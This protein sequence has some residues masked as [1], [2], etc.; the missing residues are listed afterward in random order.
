MNE[1][2]FLILPEVKSFLSEFPL[3]LVRE[4]YKSSFKY[5]SRMLDDVADFIY[6]LPIVPHYDIDER[7]S[8]YFSRYGDNLQYAFFKRKSSPRTT[9]YIFFTV[10]DKTYIVKHISTN[11][12]E[13]QYIR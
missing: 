10:K 5:A 12:T 4:G 7:F 1:Y 8:Y 13:G 9:W 2:E 6:Q 3:L 11:W